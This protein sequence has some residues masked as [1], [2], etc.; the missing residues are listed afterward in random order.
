MINHLIGE[1]SQCC[2]SLLLAEQKSDWPP[3]QGQATQDQ[4][5]S[6]FSIYVIFIY[7]LIYYNFIASCQHGVVE[8]TKQLLVAGCASSTYGCVHVT[9][10]AHDVWAGGAALYTVIHELVTNARTIWP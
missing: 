5:P 6:S 2:R 1:R 9:G 4:Q 8:Q 10:E 7:L 3:L